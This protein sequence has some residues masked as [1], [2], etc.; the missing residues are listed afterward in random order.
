ME[1]SRELQIQK[2]NKQLLESFRGYLE[3]LELSKKTMESHLSN[4]DFYINEYLLY[5]DLIE[6]KD[7]I[8]AIDMFFSYWYI[9][10]ALWASQSDMKR[11]IASIK[12]FYKHLY[13]LG[14]VSQDELKK[15][16]TIVKEGLPEWQ[17]ALDE[18]DKC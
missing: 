7:G 17:F 6:A 12:K 4:M 16:N 9:K 14:V 1:S 13:E 3:G 8:D 18:F 2:S 11:F 10:K 15:I 5:D